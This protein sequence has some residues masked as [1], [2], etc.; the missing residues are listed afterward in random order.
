[1][2]G[3]LLRKPKRLRL[4]NALKIGYSR[5]EK[6][7]ARMLKKFGYILDTELTNPRENIVAYS[8]TDRKLLY[9][10]NGTDFGNA[11]DVGNDALIVLGSQKAS[12]RIEDEKQL[13]TKA[14]NKY[15]EAKLVMA[16]HSLGGQI[17]HNIAPADAKVVT[18]N[19]AY[20]INQKVRPNFE[21]YR[22]SGDI[23]STFAPRATTTTLPNPQSRST[24]LNAFK[25]ILDSHSTENLRNVGIFL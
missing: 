7:Q 16:S 14:R 18:Y 2:E 21:N 3:S 24:Q 12:G 9:I 25:N 20:G 4:Y 13:L 8:P 11:N 22:T 6:K 17:Q 15:K 23:V 19:S 1:M 10:T 5:N